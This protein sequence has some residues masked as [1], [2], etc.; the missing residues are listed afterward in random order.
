MLARASRSIARWRC[1]G[2]SV[3][4]AA[5]R[6][7]SILSSSGCRTAQQPG[8]AAAPLGGLRLFQQI[9]EGDD[10]AVASA[11]PP[12]GAAAPGRPA[13]RQTRASGS[14]PD[15]GARPS[16]IASRTAR[17]CARACASHSATDTSVARARSRTSATI[18]A[19]SRHTSTTAPRAGW[20]ESMPPDDQGEQRRPGAARQ[21]TS[22]ATSS[23]CR[24]SSGWSRAKT[25]T[26]VSTLPTAIAAA[27]HTRAKL[28]QKMTRQASGTTS[29][30]AQ[31]P[32]QAEARPR[33]ARPARRRRTAPARRRAERAADVAEAGEVGGER[34]V[35]QRRPAQPVV[36][37]DDGGAGERGANAVGDADARR[38]RPTA[39]ATGRHP[40]YGRCRDS[41]AGQGGSIT[42]RA[43]VPGAWHLLI[44]VGHKL[45]SPRHAVP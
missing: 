3:R 20:N 21:R 16:S 2:S 37:Q 18:A 17:R 22:P 44:D 1:G 27:P 5:D 7:R 15:D 45:P 43:G 19:I 40:G 33:S 14:G 29:R 24:R 8:P 9:G 28:V 41:A 38:S 35:E 34:H 12:R 25:M 39:A 10:G 6:P 11:R 26:T 13:P 36:Q 30:Q 32:Q 4:V 31:R 23:A 42:C